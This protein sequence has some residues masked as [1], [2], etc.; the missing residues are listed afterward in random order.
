MENEK[1]SSEGNMNS[2]DFV[3]KYI[4]TLSNEIKER[5]DEIEI[6]KNQIK[7]QKKEYNQGL[8]H[9][10]SLNSK[11]I[12]T[13]NE[14][15]KI[16]NKKSKIQKEFII[17]LFSI[18]KV[19]LKKLKDPTNIPNNNI[20]KLVLFF[21]GYN[22]STDYA[23]IQKV[24]KSLDDWKELIKLGIKR[25]FNKAEKNTLIRYIND[26]KSTVNHPYDILIK[27]IELKV[28]ELDLDEKANILDNTIDQISDNKNKIFIFL[29][30][31]E[32]LILQNHSLYQGM[33]KYIKGI[34]SIF[35]KFNR[36]KQIETT[37]ENTELK[38]KLFID[39]LKSIKEFKQ[40]KFKENI[41][42]TDTTSLTI[43]SDFSDEISS[44]SITT[45]K[46]QLTN[47]LTNNNNI[48]NTK[49][50]YKQPP[51]QTPQKAK[52]NL[53]SAKF[54][55]HKNLSKPIS[56]KSATKPSKVSNMKKEINDEME[57]LYSEESQ[58]IITNNDNQ[59]L[60]TKLDFANNERS[61]IYTNTNTTFDIQ[62]YNKGNINY[63]SPLNTLSIKPSKFSEKSTCVKSEKSKRVNTI[64]YEK[65][66]NIDKCCTACT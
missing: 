32:I 11:L 56:S 46:F 17:Q 60:F 24:N 55:S 5:K 15:E 23:L 50:S 36:Y 63:I 27:I 44:L 48:S 38:D 62:E 59:I 35:E 20:C 40:H 34:Y 16:Y 49:D 22:Y 45:D 58:D 7:Q 66:V 52:Q 25:K 8:Q 39:L 14:L 2:Y 54:Y 41:F 4:S 31:I 43:R 51:T 37:R 65:N 18:N 64:I 30:N 47:Q 3:Y 12:T 26:I 61:S 33:I 29:K 6:L 9:Y 42:N 19:I 57:N 28:N 1:N 10:L 53:P 13:E 21:L